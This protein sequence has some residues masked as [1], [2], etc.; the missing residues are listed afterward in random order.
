MT[1]F[2]SLGKATQALIA[3]QNALLEE[4]EDKEAREAIYARLND[5]YD[6]MDGLI[7]KAIDAKKPEY[8]AALK[9]A[10]KA[11]AEVKKAKQKIQKVVDAMKFVDDFLKA[12]TKLLGVL[13]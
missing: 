4:T 11:V 13:A 8:D 9:A 1:D 3:E 5:L 12:V 7:D 10:G 6:I 2:E